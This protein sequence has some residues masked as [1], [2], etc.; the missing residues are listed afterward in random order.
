M[1]RR[2][3]KYIK[4]RESAPDF[5]HETSDE[6]YQ[7]LI[8]SGYYWDADAGVWIKTSSQLND[9]PSTLIKIRLWAD[10]NQV[11]DV[12]EKVIWALSGERFQLVEKSI[13]YPCRPP[14]ANDARVYLTFEKI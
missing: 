5:S 2:T 11:E 7:Y 6:L 3:R 12:A 8:K 10:K 1:I 9:P 4:A 14:K 13:T